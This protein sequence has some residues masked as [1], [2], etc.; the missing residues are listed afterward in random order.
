MIYRGDPKQEEVVGGISSYYVLGSLFGGEISFPV[1]FVVYHRGGQIDSNP[2]PI[3]TITNGA[4][5]LKYVKPSTGWVKQWYLDGYYVGH[6]VFDAGGGD[7][8][9]LG[10]DAMYFNAGFRANKGFEVLG[11]YWYGKGYYPII[12]G[13]LYSSESFNYKSPDH[14]EEQRGL[15]VLRFF[16]NQNIKPGLRVS[17]RFEP[18]YDLGNKK[19]EFSHGMVVSTNPEFL[20]RQ[21]KKI[22]F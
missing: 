15:F 18:Y 3:E 1:Q 20:I 2:T 4:V 5:G 19:F 22:K 16:L 7:T 6:K 10:G 17:T 9:Y 14:I 11:S 12:G 13:H 21:I 8:Y